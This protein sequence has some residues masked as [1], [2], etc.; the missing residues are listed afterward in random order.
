MMSICKHTICQECLIQAPKSPSWSPKHT[1]SFL[2]MEQKPR[3]TITTIWKTNDWNSI[4][5]MAHG[6]V[7]GDNQWASPAKQMF[8]KSW[9]KQSYNKP[10]TMTACFGKITALFVLF[11]FFLLYKQNTKHLHI[12]TI[13]WDIWYHPFSWLMHGCSSPVHPLGA[14]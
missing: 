10:D 1:I 14:S 7:V 5:D 4:C 2:M 12:S 3:I 11:L 13:A 8:F 6:R 9:T